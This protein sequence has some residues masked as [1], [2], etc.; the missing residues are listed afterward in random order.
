MNQS[1][2][3]YVSAT[4]S[5][6]CYALPPG[7]VYLSEVAPDIIQDMRYASANNFI[8]NP[9]PDYKRGVCIVTKQAAQ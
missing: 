1:T 8:G 5:T 9:V 6:S 4:V 3:L 2:L 7:F